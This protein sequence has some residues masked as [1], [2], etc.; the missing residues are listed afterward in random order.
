MLNAP[1]IKK[2]EN[3]PCVDQQTS[4]KLR[5]DIQALRAVAV[6][7]VVIYHFWPNVLPGGFIGVDIFFVLSGF[8]VGG[9]LIRAGSRGEP[10]NLLGFYARRIKRI[11]PS[12][13][14]TIALTMVFLWVLVPINRWENASREAIASIIYLQNLLLAQNSVDYLAQDAPDSLF[15]HFWSLSVEEQFYIVIPL[16]VLLCAMVAKRAG[17]S[18]KII[19]GGSVAL[20]VC[21]SFIYSQ[22]QVSA[23]NPAAYFT[24][25][26]R[27]WELGV[28]ALLVLL[29]AHVLRRRMRFSALLLGW[30]AIVWALFFTDPTAFPGGGRAAACLR[31]SIAAL[32]GIRCY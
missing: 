28:G 3:L 4:K 6:L 9:F 25:T 1:T 13:Y 14:I 32:P 15:R 10:I 7:A 12:A 29:P 31:N 20:L 21:A 11:L 23:G 24:L 16:L 30:G 2:S 18:P 5:A 22:I 8:L 27:L 19:V 17:W 26:S